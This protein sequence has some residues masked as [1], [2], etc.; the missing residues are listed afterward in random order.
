MT[1]VNAQD[2]AGE[3]TL[4]EAWALLQD[5][6]AAVLIDVRT[7]AEWQFVGVPALDELGKQARFVEW[8][9]YPHGAPNPDFVSQAAESLDP[10]APVLLLCR[11]GVRSLAA[12][13][14][15]TATGFAKAYNVSAGFEGDLDG[16][17]HRTS[18]WR[19]SGLPWRQG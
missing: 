11:S 5:D 12:A 13:R 3:L 14:E 4:E 7:Q 19:H 10:E 6:P 18:G 2:Y 1:S 17:G 9:T 16:D 15:L 8:T